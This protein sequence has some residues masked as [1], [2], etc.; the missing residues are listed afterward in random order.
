M[1]VQKLVY[2]LS[3]LLIC[4]VLNHYVSFTQASS[5]SF[6]G[7]GVNVGLTYPEEAHPSE[8][9]SHNLTITANEE[10]A[11]Q[12]ITLFI[13]APLNSEW[14]QIKNQTIIVLLSANTSLP[15]N[16]KF[17]IPQNANGTL[18]CLL[19]IQTDQSTDYSSFSFYTTQVRSLTYSELFAE[20][21]ELTANYSVLQQTY[22]ELVANYSTLLL[23]YI[24]LNNTYNSL[25]TNNSNLISTFNSLLNKNNALQADYGS[26]N[27]TNYILQANYGLLSSSKNVLQTNYDSLNSTY[28]KVQESYNQLKSTYDSLNQTYSTLE[29]E[30]NSLAQRINNSENALNDDRV[31]MLIFIVAIAGLIAFVAYI[32]RKKTEPYVVIRKETV[33]VKKE[34][35]R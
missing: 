1:R 32:K 14:Q 13:Y 20:Y 21:N 3:F 5:V 9:I 17:T 33:A 26:L 10:V 24:T 29:N 27:S 19:Y 16:I 6:R 35:E 7:V 4:S 15:I 8:I 22:T 18:N 2:F 31:V 30:L 34:E 11:I 23:N 28:L 25:S 12:N